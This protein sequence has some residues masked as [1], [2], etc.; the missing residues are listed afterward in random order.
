MFLGKKKSMNRAA[1]SSF[2]H[3]Y[4]LF[5]V[6]I[7]IWFFFISFNFLS[8]SYCRRKSLNRLSF[9]VI[10]FLIEILFFLTSS[11]VQFYFYSFLPR[12]RIV[13]YLTSSCVNWA[14]FGT[15]GPLKRSFHS[16]FKLAHSCQKSVCKLGQKKTNLHKN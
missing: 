4:I 11:P 16:R 9:F 6:H 5:F 14:F 1:T 12:D 2:A 7:F 15:R 8:N 10:L 3:L 13:V